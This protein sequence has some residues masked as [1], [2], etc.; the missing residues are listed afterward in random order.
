[1]L[2]LGFIEQ[3]LLMFADVVLS[4]NPV[5]AQ[6]LVPSFKE[7]NQFGQSRIYWRAPEFGV[8]LTSR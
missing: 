5:H 2:I 6:T 8:Q 3:G 1:M 7:W 4:K